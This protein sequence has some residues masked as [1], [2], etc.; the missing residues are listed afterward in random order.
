[1]WR[2]RWLAPNNPPSAPEVGSWQSEYHRGVG[3]EIP[4]VDENVRLLGHNKSTAVSLSLPL[5]WA[6][7]A[8]QSPH[9]R[10]YVAVTLPIHQNEDEILWQSNS[11]DSFNMDTVASCPR[12]FR[13]MRKQHVKRRLEA[14][15]GWEMVREPP[16][17]KRPNTH[18][19]GN[20]TSVW[21][22]CCFPSS[23]S[24]QHVA[25]NTIIQS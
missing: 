12:H 21:S 23:P 20:T 1:M 10:V 24:S 25:Q 14:A 2:V 7:R 9:V 15:S 11:P 6:R 4:H 19:Y 22:T 5:Q 18:N 3:Q 16:L 8:S 13:P 17:T